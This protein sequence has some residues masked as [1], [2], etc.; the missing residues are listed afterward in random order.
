MPNKRKRPAKGRPV[1]MRD[2]KRVNVYLDRKSL[3]RAAK[4]G[5]GNVSAG[6]RRALDQ[7]A[8]IVAITIA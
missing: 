7:A 8:R 2:G 5:D 3:E 4:L 1:S 6:I